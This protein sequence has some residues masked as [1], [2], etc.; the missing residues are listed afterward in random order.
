MLGVLQQS[1]PVTAMPAAAQP[2]GD[3]LGDIGRVFD[4]QKMHPQLLQ[5]PNAC[6]VQTYSFN[7]NVHA[8]FQS[9]TATFAHPTGC[10]AL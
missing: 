8:S 10:A 4:H 5:L 3:G 6:R 1:G 7:D 9:V 2:F